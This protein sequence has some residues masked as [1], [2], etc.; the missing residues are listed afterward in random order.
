M[1]ECYC[2]VVRVV[3]LD[4]YMTIEAAHLVD[5]E[6][7]DTTEGT[8]SYRKDL[9]FCHVCTDQTVSSALQTI[10]CDLAR[11]DIAFQSSVGNLYRKCSCHDLLVLHLAECHLL[12]A[13]IAAV[14]AHEGIAV[15]IIKLALD[16]LVV[17]ILRNGVVDIQQGNDIVRYTGTDE[18][19]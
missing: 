13:G 17:H 3:L 18:L 16:G 7:C 1:T 4:Q 9:A 11:S 10:E 15:L 6:Y 12:G 14:E 8:G 19:A 2:T 5:R